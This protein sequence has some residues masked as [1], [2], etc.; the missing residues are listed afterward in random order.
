MNNF[1]RYLP[2]DGLRLT[3][4]KISYIIRAKKYNAIYPYKHIYISLDAEHI[5]N[6]ETLYLDLLK[7]DNKEVEKIFFKMEKFLTG[8]K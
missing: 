8:P 3:V 1:E 2:C 4:N 5:Q 6:G 7:S